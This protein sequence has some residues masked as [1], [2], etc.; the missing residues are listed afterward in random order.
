MCEGRGAGYAL[1]G[2]LLT[3]VAC[4]AGI[5]ITGIAA[6]FL[7]FVAVTWLMVAAARDCVG[8]R[9]PRTSEWRPQKAISLLRPSERALLSTV[10]EE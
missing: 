2:A 7:F 10:R 5:S 8:Y 1:V 9:L 6:L 3:A 4:G